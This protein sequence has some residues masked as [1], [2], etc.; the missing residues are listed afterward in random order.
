MDN[1]EV[2]PVAKKRRPPSAGRG[3]KV[4][5]LNKFTRTLKEAILAAFDAVGG[6]EYLIA[7]AKEDPKTFCM[8]LARVL[9]LQ[10]EAELRPVGRVA[11]EPMSKEEWAERFCVD[12][13]ED[14][15]APVLIDLTPNGHGI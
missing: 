4:G 7:V 12:R 15:P 8:L 2:T 5:E 3:R 13:P 10:V 11:R 9:P 1:K 14:K 6:R